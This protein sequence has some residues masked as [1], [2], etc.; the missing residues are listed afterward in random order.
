[1]V[2]SCAPAPAATALPLQEAATQIVIEELGANGAPGMS[3][4][5]L[6]D[7]QTLARVAVGVS[8][9]ETG[10]EVSSE[11]AFPAGSVTKILTAALVMTEVD[12]GRLDLDAPIAPHL[13][14]GL[15]PLDSGGA[16]V[17]VTLRQLLSHSSG[18]PVT[19]DGFP[20]N[21]PVE[22]RDAYIAGSRTIV[23]PPGDRLVYSNVGL[24]LAGEVAAASAGIRFEDLAQERLFT[25]L[26]MTRSSLKQAADYDG[27]LAAGHARG[28]GDTVQPTPHIDLTPMA[29]AGSLLTTPD[30][31]ARFATM[32]LDGGIFEGSRILSATAVDAMMTLQAPAHPELDEGFGLGFGVRDDRRKIWWDGTTTAAAAHFAL[33]PEA[34]TAV[35]V[36]ANIADNQSTSVA[37]RRLLE[38]A[39]PELVPGPAPALLP[40]DGVEGYYLAEDLVDPDLW[41]FAYTMPLAVRTD[42]ASLVVSFGLTGPM[43]FIPVGPDR[44]RVMGGML[45][46]ASVLMTGD[47]LQAGFVRAE[48]LPALLTPPAL[49][50]YAGV[51]ALSVLVGLGYG[52]RAV[53][54]RFRH[55]AQAN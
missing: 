2:F 24:V 50:T 36:M 39:V 30:D 41:F 51:I 1:M 4:I 35:I 22:S 10:V 25:P 34:D 43:T 21:P 48:R 17:D 55:R 11:T 26:G 29:A 53:W 3:A 16:E 38:L 23:Y 42:G 27:P 9:G 18:L 31:L 37:G 28:S 47:M 8:D 40:P 46:G 6:R 12:A 13:P 45:D 32:L 33:L 7:G 14:P 20:P 19:W 49:W 52:I 5:L 44:F 15:R 54:R